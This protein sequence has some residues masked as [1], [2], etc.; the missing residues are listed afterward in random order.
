MA[1]SV[2]K[3]ALWRGETANRPGALADVLAPLAAAGADLKV[4]MGYVVPGQPAN[5]VIE[6]YPVTTKKAAAAAG[7]AGLAAAATPCLVVEGD[8]RPGLGHAMAQSLAGSGINLSFVV[9]QVV[10]R[11]YAALFGFESDADAA[12]ATKL[13]KS[14]GAKRGK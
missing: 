14:A 9:A 4:V 7:R 13:L 8:N 3:A 6:V 12:K 11:K 1:I 5:G 10:G 2:K